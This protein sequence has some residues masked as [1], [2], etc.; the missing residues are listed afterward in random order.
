[1]TQA[2]RMIRAYLASGLGLVLGPFFDFEWSILFIKELD[3]Q[4]EDYP[5]RLDVHISPASKQEILQIVGCTQFH[6]REVLMTRFEA[7]NLCLVAK[8]GDDLAGFNW[9]VFTDVM[10]ACYFVRPGP[11]D[12]YCMDARTYEAYRGEG[13]HTRLLSQLL[14]HARERGA[15]R[16][17]TRASAANSASWKSHV[18]L[19]WKEAGSFVMLRPKFGR[20]RR[21][22]GGPDRYPLALD[23]SSG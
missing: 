21:R 19:G 5:A 3:D 4:L 15:S 12:V 2:L 17:F 22:F 18:R 16:A 14:L 1:M 9:V 20:N 7:G 11:G 13:L 6:T 8:Q 10:D 23:R